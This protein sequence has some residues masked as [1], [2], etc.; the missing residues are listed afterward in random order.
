MDTRIPVRFLP[1]ATSMGF[2]ISGNLRNATHQCPDSSFRCLFQGRL[3]RNGALPAVGWWAQ[4]WLPS[5]ECSC[6]VTPTQDTGTYQVST[7]H[8]VHQSPECPVSFPPTTQYQA[9]AWP[10]RN[11]HRF[12]LTHC[13]FRNGSLAQEIKAGMFRRDP[14]LSLASV[15]GQL[16]RRNRN[17]SS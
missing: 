5:S 9:G 1:G 8:R 15:Q 3:G 6:I 13:A 7:G 10:P 17:H 4:E 12:P 11:N 2:R 16:R 14:R